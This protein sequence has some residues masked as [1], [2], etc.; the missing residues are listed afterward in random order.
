MRAWLEADK[1]DVAASVVLVAGALVTPILFIPNLFNPLRLSKELCFEVVLVVSCA[2]QVQKLIVRGRD[3]LPDWRRFLRIPFAIPALF[4]LALLVLSLMNQANTDIDS[5]RLLSLFLVAY[6]LSF[7]LL[8]VKA[9]KYLIYGL[10]LAGCVNAVVVFLQSRQI[11]VFSNPYEAASH[12]GPTTERV[13]FTGLLGNPNELAFFL[14][15]T[16]LLAF[17]VVLRKERYWTVL[18]GFLTWCLSLLGIYL[19]LTFSAIIAFVVAMLVPFFFLLWKRWRRHASMLLFVLLIAPPVAGGYVFVQRQPF[20]QERITRIQQGL[21]E[22]NLNALLSDR[23]YPWLIGLHMAQDRPYFGQGLGGYQKLYF[24]FKARFLERNPDTYMTPLYYT[25]AHNE[26]IQ[27]MAELGLVGLAIFGWFIL[28]YLIR[29]WRYF[30]RKQ[31]EPDGLLD[32]GLYAV[33]IAA[34]VNCLAHFTFHTAALAFLLWVVLT[35]YARH[36]CS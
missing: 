16:A 9:E 26:F 32:L 36:V 10:M 4:I 19:T 18:L 20:L 34:L 1:L 5:A 33:G 24:D 7:L 28:E 13:Y 23:Y 11:M 29:S 22:K 3:L 31:T 6:L 35:V 2:L 17:H 8:P 15:G 12:L 27:I 14:V 21:A 30:F 25:F